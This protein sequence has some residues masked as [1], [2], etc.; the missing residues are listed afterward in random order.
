MVD[1]YNLVVPQ[2]S[3]GNRCEAFV[4]HGVIFFMEGLGQVVVARLLPSIMLLVL[5]RT[6]SV[7]QWWRGGNSTA[8]Q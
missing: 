4:M 2:I 7:G 8:R 5:M 6:V 1:Y 3:L